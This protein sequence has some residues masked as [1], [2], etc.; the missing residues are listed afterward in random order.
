MQA[1][2]IAVLPPTVTM[3]D[4]VSKAVQLMVVKQVPGLIVVDDRD[5]PV[6]VLSGAKV[7]GL[8]IPGCYQGDSAL[9]RAVDESHADQFW[10]ESAKLTVRDCLPS[11]ITKPA[12]VASDA[13]LLEV[14][15]A[16]ATRQSPL[17]ALVDS[18]G[19]LSGAVTLTRLLTSLGMAGP[20]D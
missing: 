17:V 11:P 6:A 13:T 19:R 3:D 5:H 2:E 8:V 20:G 15:S 14:A 7:L 16:M 18:D 12:V 9:V 4:S 1:S 10:Q